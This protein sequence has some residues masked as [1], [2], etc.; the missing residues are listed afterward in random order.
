VDVAFE[1]ADQALDDDPSVVGAHGPQ[2]AISV[3]VVNDLCR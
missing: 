1:G 3:E 2:G